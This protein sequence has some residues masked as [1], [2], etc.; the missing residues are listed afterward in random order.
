MINHIIVSTGLCKPTLQLKF[1]TEM[2]RERAIEWHKREGVKGPRLMN[3]NVPLLLHASVPPLRHAPCHGYS[4]NHSIKQS[5]TQRSTF[6]PMPNLPLLHSQA[7]RD[8]HTHSGEEQL[9][10]L[11]EHIVYQQITEP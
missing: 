9:S 7:H 2:G 6:L 8:T 3:G 10:D 11:S 5:N 1:E 4:I